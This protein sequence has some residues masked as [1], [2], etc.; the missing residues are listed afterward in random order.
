MDPTQYQHARQQHMDLCI[1]NLASVMID[2]ASPDQ[3]NRIADAI[4][5]MD[6][7]N[8]ELLKKA[9]REYYD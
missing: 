9:D 2:M 1:R 6:D 3:Q 5:H 4:Q 8:A 7:M